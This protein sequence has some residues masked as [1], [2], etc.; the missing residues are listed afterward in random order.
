MH[1]GYSRTGHF[2]RLTTAAFVGKEFIRRN[3]A[4]V[5]ILGPRH[6]AGRPHFEGNKKRTTCGGSI[7]LKC[8]MAATSFQGHTI[9]EL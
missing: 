5:K 6:G 1:V 9:V 3:N 4:I 8:V 7:P 2:P